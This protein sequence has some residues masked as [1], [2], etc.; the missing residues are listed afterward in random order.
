MLE[1]L[2]FGKLSLDVFPKD[3]ITLYGAGSVLFLGA[4]SVIG[5]LTYFKKWRYVWEEWVCTVDHKKIGIMYIIL[6]F[7]MFFE[8][9]FKH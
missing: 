7:I 2:I 6:A 5:S 4:A 1:Q 9:W 3:A 8:H